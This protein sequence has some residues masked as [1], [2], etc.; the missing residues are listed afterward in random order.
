[1]FEGLIANWMFL[2]VVVALMVLQTLSIYF[3]GST[4]GVYPLSEKQHAF[5]VIWGFTAIPVSAFLKWLPNKL[6]EKLPVLVDENKAV[7]EDKLMNAFN[8]QANAK[9]FK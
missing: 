2:V 1:V 5:C 4:I 3:L 8:S 7:Q 9:A 6:A